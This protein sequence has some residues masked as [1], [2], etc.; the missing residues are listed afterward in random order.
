MGKCH[1]R[2]T[3][4][5]IEAG[6]WLESRSSRLVWWTKRDTISNNWVN[7]Q[8]IHK[9]NISTHLHFVTQCGR[10]TN[11]QLGDCDRGKLVSWDNDLSVISGAY[12]IS[13]W[14]WLLSLLKIFKAYYLTAKFR[15]TFHFFFKSYKWII[16]TG[17]TVQSGDCKT[18]PK[19]WS[20]DFQYHCMKL[21]WQHVSQHLGGREKEPIIGIHR[22]LQNK[23][24][25]DLV[26][27]KKKRT[28]ENET[29]HHQGLQAPLSAVLL[30]ARKDPDRSHSICTGHVSTHWRV[31]SSISHNLN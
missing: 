23:S 5:K 8:N 25:R 2:F 1:Y 11:L 21:V 4:Q 29:K 16:R 19:L 6:G 13:A 9:H 10:F 31:A 17:F 18:R 20:L 26:S 30:P 22:D 27:K 14:V 12:V 15:V 3:T 24:V 7:T 28:T